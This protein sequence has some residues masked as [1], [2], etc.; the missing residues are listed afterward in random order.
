MCWHV[1]QSQENIPVLQSNHVSEQI[2]DPPDFLLPHVRV[3][4][5]FLVGEY[6]SHKFLFNPGK[7]KNKNLF[8]SI[9]GVPCMGSCSTLCTPLVHSDTPQPQPKRKVMETK[10]CCFPNF[11]EHFRFFR[12]WEKGT[13]MWMEADVVGDQKIVALN[14]NKMGGYAGLFLEVPGKEEWLCCCIFGRRKHEKCVWRGHEGVRG[15]GRH[16]EWFSTLS[17]LLKSNTPWAFFFFFRFVDKDGPLCTETVDYRLFCGVWWSQNSSGKRLYSLS[18][19][20]WSLTGNW[21]NM[22]K[23]AGSVIAP[24][25]QMMSTTGKTW[26]QL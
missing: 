23:I 8:A 24:Y 9:Y 12:S 2:E 5:C 10:H 20:P 11:L 14:E 21:D 18:S 25:S 26:P 19:A 15:G 3:F 17:A 4:N 7:K 13:F 1:L 16:Y 22:M 6:L